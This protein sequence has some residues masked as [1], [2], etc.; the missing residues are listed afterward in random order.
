MTR[1]AEEK[2]GA[3]FFFS[4]SIF[5]LFLFCRFFFFCL[6]TLLLS[7][8]AVRSRFAPIL[9][10]LRVHGAT[11]MVFAWIGFLSFRFPEQ[12]ASFPFGI[13]LHISFSFFPLYLLLV[14]Q[15]LMPRSPVTTVECAI[16]LVTGYLL[17]LDFVD[18]LPNYYWLT[19]FLFDVILLSLLSF[20]S[21]HSSS[22]S[23]SLASS[24]SGYSLLPLSEGDEVITLERL[25]VEVLD[26]S[27]S[28]QEQNSFS[29]SARESRSVAFVDYDDEDGLERNRYRSSRFGIS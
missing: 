24:L 9:K 16:G 18:F 12:E 11:G 26:T 20:F 19:C 3:F 2:K 13:P 22:S 4:N 17:S 8:S 25:R 1:I 15:V 10:S 14:F 28:S 29:F 27:H 23:S 6:L 7:F 5:L 21:Q